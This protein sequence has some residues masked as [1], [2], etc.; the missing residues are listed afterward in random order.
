MTMRFRPFQSKEE[1]IN[2]VELIA[3]IDAGEKWIF[4]GAEGSNDFGGFIERLYFSHKDT[5]G[6]FCTCIFAGKLR[7]HIGFNTDMPEELSE[8][9]L[10]LIENSRKRVNTFTSIW[11]VPS[12]HKLDSFL[13]SMLPWQAKGHK[14]HELTV[15]REDFENIDCVLPKDIVIIPFEEKYLERTC[16]MLDLSLAHTF[17]NPTIG[18]FVNNRDNLKREWTEKARSGECCLMIE[19]NQVLG[20]YILKGAEI[21]FLAIAIDKQG[22]GL[23]KQLLR[24]AI[25]HILSSSED[26]P[27]LYCIDRNPKALHF[28]M[29][30]GMKVTGHSGYV[31]FP[32]Q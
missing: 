20:A 24:H 27:Y 5:F 9:L 1:E 23:G 31:F 30:E 2:A 15:M 32:E 3:T 28:Y 19:D 10:T 8:E 21:D 25:K 26:S 13:F 18:L 17:D 16:T 11:Y 14:T 29:R 12:N 6:T 22:K 7:I 4:S